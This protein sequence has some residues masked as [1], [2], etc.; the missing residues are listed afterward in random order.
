MTLFL[1]D[2]D[3]DHVDI[4]PI[5]KMGR[6]AVDSNELFIDDLPVPVERPRRRGG[7]GL[8][9]PARRPQPRADPRRPRGD[10]H[11]PR[12]A[13]PGGRLRQRAG[14]VRPAR[15]AMNQGDPVPAGRRAGPARR[16][17]ADGA[18]RRPG[19]TTRAGRAAREANIAK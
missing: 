3:R 17:R 5:E 1:T 11:R 13:A 18:A 15:S 6:N 9:V 2:L 12:R 14:G 4:R 16:G 19:C 7:Q 10:R 8:P